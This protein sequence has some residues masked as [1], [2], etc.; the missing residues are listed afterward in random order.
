MNR[1][2]KFRCW[3]EHTKKMM[4]TG[5]VLY[6]DGTMEFPE[7]GWDLH[8]VDDGYP[9]MQYTVLKDR[10]GREIYDKDVLTIE[11]REFSPMNFVV[12]WSDACHG[13]WLTSTEKLFYSGYSKRLFAFSDLNGFHHDATVIGNIYEHP[14]LLNN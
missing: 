1:E 7:G 12:E 3:V 6:P 11:N 14:E 10:N 8:G 13:W 2:L 5:F 4:T 9:L